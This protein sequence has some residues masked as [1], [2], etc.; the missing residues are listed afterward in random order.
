MYPF[1]VGDIVRYTKSGRTFEIEDVNPN[2]DY[3]EDDEYGKV[4]WDYR[5]HPHGL[6][7]LLGRGVVGLALCRP[8]RLVS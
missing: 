3:A 6:G 8:L 1:N 7:N 2:P 4:C 5:G